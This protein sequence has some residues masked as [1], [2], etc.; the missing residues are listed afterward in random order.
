MAIKFQYNKT[1]LQALE[2]QLKIRVRALPTIKN[3]ESA[4]RMEVTRN[5]EE[6][7]KLE[8]RLEKEIQGYDYMA[9]LWNEFTPDLVSVSD[10]SL[11]TKKIAG[12]VV[13]VLTGVEFEEKLYSLFGA[14]LWTADGIEMLKGLAR[15]GIE[16]EF[17]RMK[18]ELLEYARKKTTQKVNLFEKVQIPGYKDSIRKVKRY[19]EDEESLSK[20]S[21]KIMRANQEKRKKKEEEAQL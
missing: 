11:A 18:L 14:P 9:A 15:T 5:K 20:A 6:V 13:P 4:L 19:M 7:G 17:S 1:S 10:V 16:A 8:L 12:V 2:K 3:K 21:Q